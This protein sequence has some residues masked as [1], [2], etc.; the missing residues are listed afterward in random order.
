MLRPDVVWFGEALPEEVMGN[1][2]SAARQADLFLVIGTSAL[3][4]PAAGL[5]QIARERGAYLV[6][7]NI[8]PTPLSA[9]ADEVIMGPAAGTLAG[10]LG[11]PGGHWTGIR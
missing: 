8:E 6:E 5:P 10:L 2:F 9:D 4:Y 1:A 7:I 3:V 11:G